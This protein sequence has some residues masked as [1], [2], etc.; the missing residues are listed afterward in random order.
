MVNK[1][2]DLTRT[3]ETVPASVRD[4]YRLLDHHAGECIACGHCE[5]NCP[6][7]VPVIEKMS[8]AAETFGY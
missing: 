4:H 5:D 6:F 3:Q 1:F 7:D 8:R 2:H